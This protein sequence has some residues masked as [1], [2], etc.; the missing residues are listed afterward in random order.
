NLL[1]YLAVL[2]LTLFVSARDG[3]RGPSIKPACKDGRIEVEIS[4]GGGRRRQPKSQSFSPVRDHS[5]A[6]RVPI[7][8]S[9][10]LISNN[11]FAGEQL[12]QRLSIFRD[13]FEGSF[14]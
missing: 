5:P 2:T 6:A 11:R 4:V 14:L 9:N 13:A 10:A 12:H 8:G 3:R 7:A 1:D